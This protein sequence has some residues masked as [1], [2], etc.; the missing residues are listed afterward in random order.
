MGY[1]AQRK[2]S[3]PRRSVVVRHGILPA[4]LV[5]VLA[6]ARGAA[7]QTIATASNLVATSTWHSV[8]LDLS[9]APANTRFAGY[10][11]VASWQN[12]LN[13]SSSKARFMLTGSA[14]TGGTSLSPSNV[15]VYASPQSSPFW[16]GGVR[17]DANPT[18]LWR[19]GPLAPQLIC[20]ATPPQLFLCYLQTS[21]AALWAT[22]EVTLNADGAVAPN[23]TPAGAV[24]VYCAPGATVLT[25]PAFR[26]ALNPRRV[27]EPAPDCVGGPAFV[28]WYAFT[29]LETGQFEISTCAPDTPAV[30]GTSVFV[31]AFDGGSDPLLLACS[32]GECGGAGAQRGKVTLS[33]NAGQRCLVATGLQLG[34]SMP[35]NPASADVVQVRIKSLTPPTPLA[36][37]A[38]ADI[39]DDGGDPLPP[40]FTGTSANNGINEGDYNCFFNNFFAGNPVCDIATDAGDPAPS[41]GPAGAPNA[42]VNEGDY[43]CFFNTFFAGCH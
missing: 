23:D 26:A 30:T 16:N 21:G 35:T 38:P 42:G 36:R 24:T 31:A 20:N 32:S 12:T 22:A 43:N 25:P 6:G 4:I 29:P 1:A 37:C 14:V 19:A 5:L 2:Q 28:A 18:E 8:E 3:R 9:G 7:A 33:L 17:T 27:D 34:G 40:F 41:F 11:V 15:I 39:G 13:S 10:F